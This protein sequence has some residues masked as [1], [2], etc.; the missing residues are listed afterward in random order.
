MKPRLFG[1]AQRRFPGL[2]YAVQAAAQRRLQAV[3]GWSD[4]SVPGTLGIDPGTRL[5]AFS[6]QGYL[7]IYS[8]PRPTDREF[9]VWK[10]KRVR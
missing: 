2:P 4:E 7:F 3:A 5:R 8:A 9:Y 6:L 1:Q 10:I